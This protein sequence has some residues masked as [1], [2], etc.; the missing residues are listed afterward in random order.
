VTDTESD[1]RFEEDLRCYY[2]WLNADS[3][4]G[5][6]EL[7]GDMLHALDFQ[8]RGLACIPSK[9]FESIRCVTAGSECHS[10][11]KSSCRRHSHTRGKHWSA[12]AF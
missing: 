1:S 5:R 3:S 4:I 6:T 9:A 10:G 2:L 12:S 11:S 7:L 8:E